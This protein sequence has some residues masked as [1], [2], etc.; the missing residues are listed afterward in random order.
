MKQICVNCNKVFY[1]TKNNYVGYP[2]ASSGYWDHGEDRWIN[3][4]SDTNAKVFHSRWCQDQFLN[5]HGTY[6]TRI[7]RDLKTNEREATND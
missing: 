1:P 4:E 6:L 7:F 5:R 3:V 2:Q